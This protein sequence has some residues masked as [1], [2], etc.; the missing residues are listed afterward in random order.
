MINVFIIFATILKRRVKDNLYI[1]SFFSMVLL[2]LSS[3]ASTVKITSVAERNSE[4]DFLLKWEVSPDQDGKIEI[5][6]SLSDSSRD[7]FIPIVSTSVS[8]QFALINPTG[9]QMR[10]F[11]VL[12]ASGVY[13]GI[14]SNRVIEMN[15][16]KNFRDLGGYFNGENRQMRW[17]KIYRS[18]DL[19]SA[20][21]F[22]QDRLRKLGIKTILDLRSEKN[23]KAHPIFFN[24]N[25]RRIALPMAGMD[26]DIMDSHINKRNFTRSD[27]IRYVQ[28]SYIDIVENYKGVLTEMFDVLTA[29]DN[30]PV[31][32]SETLGKDRVGLV[33][34]LILSAIGIPENTIMDDYLFSNQ[35]IDPRTTIDYAQTLP[36]YIQEA[37]TALLSVNRVYLDY[38]IDYIKQKYGSVDNYLQKELNVTPAKKS[39]LKKYLLYN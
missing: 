19:S 11:F 14:V 5:Y 32:I 20:D 9:S 28:D 30:Y 39:L 15:H 10:E 1:A 22:D 27:A 35:T 8:D 25:I 24:P 38:T 4:G 23:A 34:F 21:L 3:C 36:E 18:G 26:V 37:I 33:S 2:F 31:I 16:I 12:R 7:A 6:S 17:G 13:S 29:E